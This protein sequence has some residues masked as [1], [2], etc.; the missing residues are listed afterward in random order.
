MSLFS[1]II[2]ITTFLLLF[3]GYYIYTKYQDKIYY[4]QEKKEFERLEKL[5]VMEEERLRKLENEKNKQKEIFEQSIFG[6]KESVKYYLYNIDVLDYKLSNLYKDIVIKNLWI[7]E[8]F[9]TKFYEFLMLINDNH[10]MII[11][12]Y[13]K[14]ITMNI[15]DE[16][17]IVQTSKSYQVYS[18]KDIIKHTIID[19][20]HDIKR[21]NKND[22][23]NLIILIFIVVLKQSVHYL[24]KEVPQS[25]IDRMLKDYKQAPRI[26]N[27]VQMFEVKNEKVYFI[28]ESLND[29]FS[30]VETLPYNDSEVEKAIK[31]RRQISPKLLRQI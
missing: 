21:F 16:H 19:C 23:Q 29:A 17:N 13:S 10:F 22:A 31:I 25:I 5:K 24:S 27:I 26:K 14:V 2:I 12:P 4:E 8:P 11:D 1:I 6:K 18:A 7:N 15:R 9:H 3:L 28:Q 30:V 20:I